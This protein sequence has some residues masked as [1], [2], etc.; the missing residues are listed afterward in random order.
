MYLDRP[1]RDIPSNINN[2]QAI[3]EQHLTEVVWAECLN[4]W[5]RRLDT[6]R[7]F[8]LFNALAVN[9]STHK[10][11]NLSQAAN[12]GIHI[13]LLF[14]KVDAIPLAKIQQRHSLKPISLETISPKPHQ[15]RH[16]KHI[17]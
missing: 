4:A 17:E 5:S 10:T 16:E 15:Q 6:A 3:S 12:A 14:Q 9:H 13:C 1:N 2:I 7:H 8:K 11:L